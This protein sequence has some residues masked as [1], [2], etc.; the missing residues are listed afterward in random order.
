[1]VKQSWFRLF[2]RRFY[3]T[4]VIRERKAK[5]TFVLENSPAHLAV[6]WLITDRLRRYA[7][8]A[9]TLFHS[10]E[11]MDSYKYVYEYG[12]GDENSL[13]ELPFVR[14]GQNGHTRPS[15][16]EEMADYYQYMSRNHLNAHYFSRN[17]EYQNYI[18]DN[19]KIINSEW[20]SVAR[21][22]A[23]E[24]AVEGFFEGCS[25]TTQLVNKLLIP[26]VEEAL[27]GG[28]T[29]DFVETFEKQREHF[30]KHR[31]LQDKI[32]ESAGRYA[33]QQLC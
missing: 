7:L 20:K 29:K 5:D 25:T 1:M 6:E 27:A 18:E 14:K 32:E 2:C 22:N 10:K 28:G 17:R 3:H 26:T 12:S 21:I 4:Y 16:K 31:Q 8:T 19:F 33:N 13:E 9:V 30:K 24:G 23:A 11:G 15:S